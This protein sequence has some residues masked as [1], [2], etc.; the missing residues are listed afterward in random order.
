[1]SLKVAFNWGSHSAFGAGPGQPT[2]A[3][4]LELIRNDPTLTHGKQLALVAELTGAIGNMPKSTPL[5]AIGSALFGAVISNLV[6]KYFGMGIIGRSVA[7][8]AGFG[9]G[10][11]IYGKV[12]DKGIPGWSIS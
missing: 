1:M 2:I 8:A 5:G 11:V 9:V 12:R 3:E 7:T 6:A 10:P 4:L